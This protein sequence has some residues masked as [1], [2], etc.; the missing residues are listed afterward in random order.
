M[1]QADP[2]RPLAF[3]IDHLCGAY[4]KR[5]WNHETKRLCRFQVDGQVE[6]G[7]LLDWQI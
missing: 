5:L 4:Q 2:E 1:A 7:R 6:A 3:L